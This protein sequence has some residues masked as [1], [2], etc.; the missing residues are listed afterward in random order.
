[1]KKF[2]LFVFVIASAAQ[3]SPAQTN[4]Y[5]PFPDSNAYWNEHTWGLNTWHT[6]VTDD[7]YA[8]FINGDTTI[9]ANTYHKIYK[10]GYTVYSCWSP[11]TN[12]VYS[13]YGAYYH[14]AIRQD[15]L[16]K[17]VFYYFGNEYLLYDF[18]LNLGDTLPQTYI[19]GGFTVSNIDSVLVGTHYHKRFIL[20]S[21][22]PFPSP[23]SSH[24]IVEGIGSSFGLTNQ[25]GFYPEGGGNWVCFS[26]NTE[27]YPAN[28]NCSI[29]TNITETVS[30]NIQINISPNPFTI[31]TI[32]HSSQELNKALLIIYNSFGQEVKETKNISGQTITLQR[33]NLPSGIYFFR[34]TQDN[35]ILS[36]DKLV[37]TSY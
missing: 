7:Y 5:H 3:Q 13:Y 21:N 28:S 9:G 25:I 30:S 20:Q 4:V 33:E 36:A 11:P 19:G 35:K 10:Q 24:C 22:P 1:M 26:H 15:S 6:C 16:Q 8:L 18:N 34:L 17:K 31:Q 32:L 29:T 23:D 2:L 12:P 37:I 14:C 27:T